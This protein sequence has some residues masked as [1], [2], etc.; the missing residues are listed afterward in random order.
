M[1]FS[2]ERSPT[3]IALAL[4]L[5]LTLSGGVAGDEAERIPAPNFSCNEWLNSPPLGLSQLRN[6]VVLIDFWEYTCINCIRTFPYLRRWQKLYGPLGLV[7]IGVHTPEFAFAKNPKNVAAA[8]KR[9]GFTFPIAVDSDYKVWDAFHNEAWPADYLIDKNGNIAFVHLGEGNY[10]EMER[11]I[12]KLLKE[13]NPKLDFAAAQFAITDDA[14]GFGGACMRPTPETY[15]GYKRAY[16]IANPGGEDRTQEV[17]YVA[18]SEVPIDNFAL[19]GNW[20]ASPESVQH[21]S[22]AKKPGDSLTLHYQAKSVYM[23]AGSDDGRHKRVYVTQ[24]GAP[25]PKDA[26]NVDIKTDSEG[27]TY[28]ELTGKQMYYLVNNPQ[29]GTHTLALY[30]IDPSLSLY[31]FTFGNNCENKFAHR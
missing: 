21:V 2:I 31:S 29:F 15:L 22:A 24:D 30:V 19:N 27:R 16:T 12:Q 20:L 7:I 25:L 28:I 6:R 14:P 4:A 3:T 18:P 8:V 26:R 1:R 13:V 17:H 23:V 9:F 10:A 5:T 11:H